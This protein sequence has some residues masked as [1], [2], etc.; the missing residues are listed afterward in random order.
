MSKSSHFPHWGWV[1]LGSLV[2]TGSSGIF[3]GWSCVLRWLDVTGML[4]EN[5][6]VRRGGCLWML[7]G[8]QGVNQWVVQVEAFVVKRQHSNWEEMRTF[9]SGETVH[10]GKRLFLWVKTFILSNRRILLNFAI[11]VFKVLMERKVPCILDIL[12]FFS[13]CG[14]EGVTYGALT[15]ILEEERSKD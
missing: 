6:K 2:G 15:A 11:N 12:C 5:S 7:G 1:L 13:D 4:L 9:S 14:P 10:F 8:R 3:G